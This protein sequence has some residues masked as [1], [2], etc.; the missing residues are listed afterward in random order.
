MPAVSLLRHAADR[1][2]LGLAAAHVALVAATLVAWQAGFPGWF[3]AGVTAPVLAASAFVQLISVHNAMHAPIFRAKRLNRAW[4]CALSICIGYPVSI[5]V[6]VHN[7]SHHLGLQ[8]PRDILRTTEV[9]HGW[10]L[11]NLVHHMVMGTVH[12]HLLHFAYLATM[13]RSRPR[14]LAQVGYEAAATAVYLGAIAFVVGPVAMVL[15]VWLPAILGQLLMVGFG[16]V[17]HDGCDADSEYHHS[18]N[19]TSP[20]LNWFICDNGYHTAHHN[21]PALHWSRGKAAHHAD[22][23]PN[24]DPRLDEPSLVAYLARAFVWPGRRLRFDGRPVEL[25]PQR[26]RRE[27]WTP[28]SAITSGASSGAV[29]G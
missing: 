6:P 27:L 18:R 25:P 26:A 11:L 14:W 2:A 29:E 8:T 7:L 15:L 21:R 3:F 24:M 5:Y 19:F 12:L 9:R 16:Y 28:V 1:R 13:R 4:Q 23:V 20:V 22:V 17:Q 10:N